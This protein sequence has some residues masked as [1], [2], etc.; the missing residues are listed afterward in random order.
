MAIFYNSF[1]VYLWNGGNQI[2]SS[3]ICLISTLD[4][5][6]IEASQKAVEKVW[7]R[8]AVLKSIEE[9]TI[10]EKRE[11]AEVEAAKKKEGKDIRS[12]FKNSRK[13]KDKK[14]KDAKGIGKKT[15]DPTIGEDEGK[16]KQA[17][18]AKKTSESKKSPKLKEK[19]KRDQEA[20]NSGTQSDIQDIEDEKNRKKHKKEKKDK[21]KS[22]EH[23][24]DQ[25]DQSDESYDE[26][27]EE[28][29]ESED[30]FYIPRGRVGGLSFSSLFSKTKQ[31]KA[32][33]KRKNKFQNDY[34]ASADVQDSN[35]R[36]DSQEEK[37]EIKSDDDLEKDEKENTFRRSGR[38]KRKPEHVML[39]D[40]D[41]S[42]ELD[43][44]ENNPG[45]VEEITE[46][47]GKVMLNVKNGKD[48]R[49]M[50]KPKDCE[51]NDNKAV[52]SKTTMNDIDHIKKVNLKENKGY[53]VSEIKAKVKEEVDKIKKQN[54]HKS[55]DIR[56][57]FSG[58]KK[59]AKTEVQ[60]DKKNFRQGEKETN[61]ITM[62]ND[63]E[64]VMEVDQDK[65]I[66][67]V[68]RPQEEFE[69]EI[70]DAMNIVEIGQCSEKLKTN[71]EKTC[72]EKVLVCNDSFKDQLQP[73][74]TSFES[75][76]A[77]KQLQKPKK[78]IRSFF[79][80]VEHGKGGSLISMTEKE[81][82][83]KV[84]RDKQKKAVMVEPEKL[85]QDNQT[86]SKILEKEHVKR[87][88]ADEES[89]DKQSVDK[90]ER[91][92]KYKETMS[93][94]VEKRNCRSLI[95]INN[96]INEESNLSGKSKHLSLISPC[97]VLCEPLHLP[98]CKEEPAPERI[99][100]KRKKSSTENHVENKRM[101]REAKT[102]SG[103]KQSAATADQGKRRSLRNKSKE[104][105][106][107]TTIKKEIGDESSGP[108]EDENNTK[109][110]VATTKFVAMDSFTDYNEITPLP[111]KSDTQI[112]MKIGRNKKKLSKVN[113][114]C[115]NIKEELAEPSS[116][117]R[118][119]TSLRRSSRARKQVVSYCE[120]DFVGELKKKNKEAKIK[121][122]KRDNET[123]KK[124][125]LPEGEGV[126][127]LEESVMEVSMTNG[128][129]KQRNTPAAS[130]MKQTHEL[131]QKRTKPVIGIFFSY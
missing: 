10:K 52:I 127:D 118:G 36:T 62:S 80:K 60:Q 13:K 29:Q 112:C 56:S 83:V 31:R 71:E 42:S 109:N 18:K 92:D 95:S 100:R 25:Q 1:V 12:M 94:P 35:E 8:D 4:L 6:K 55:K 107:N 122:E 90:E 82:A 68:S 99:S 97:K 46:T 123:P 117:D 120:E 47:P 50:F 102:E 2:S 3:K 63:V 5:R 81:E 114:Q 108:L 28:L 103:K 111:E 19:D 124:E 86:A 21:E 93:I 67:E 75:E 23:E 22:F 91:L 119:N 34:I 101:K 98:Q 65:S 115:G 49:S 87:K 130:P 105:V 110:D 88:S 61:Q 33:G 40:Y 11:K 84:S 43:M 129:G 45:A 79:A 113:S 106:G 116:A 48:I 54:Q 126:N 73:L 104:I 9:V 41:H 78:D 57:L 128:E 96:S 72:E 26:L 38:T 59:G 131:N 125:E 53:L 44:S 58:V 30:D 20:V 37:M 32:R 74:E 14:S 24:K 85:Y 70:K 77:S 7:E 66:I 17:D 16:N 64:K 15:E 39:E 51:S 69:M 121:G 76:S 27:E 89:A